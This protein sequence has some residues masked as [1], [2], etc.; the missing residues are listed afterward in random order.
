MLTMNSVKFIPQ[1]SADVVERLLDVQP[2]MEFDQA[3][4]SKGLTNVSFRPAGDKEEGR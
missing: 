2:S 4:F 1:I 3:W